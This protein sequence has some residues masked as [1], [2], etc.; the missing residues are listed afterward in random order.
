MSRASK[1]TLVLWSALLLALA[2]S[3]CQTPKPK[4]LQVCPTPPAWLM[5]PPA[6]LQSIEIERSDSRSQ[7]TSQSAD[8]S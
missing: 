8:E 6:T 4:I 3:A 2:L 5:E 1:L 7:P